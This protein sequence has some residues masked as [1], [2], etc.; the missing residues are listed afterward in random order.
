M[1][2]ASVE[3]SAARCASFAI[4]LFCAALILVPPTAAQND[5]PYPAGP[6]GGNKLAAAL[7]SMRPEENSRWQGQLKI[8]R[9][10]QTLV[11]PAGSEVLV[12]G[13]NWKVIY[14]AQATDKTAAEKLIVVH[15]TNGPNQYFYARASSPS[16]VPGEPKSLGAAEIDFP[17]ASSDFW[18][19]DL[20]FEFYHWPDQRCLKGEMRRGR[21]CYVLESRNPNPAP[22]GYSRVVSWI[23]RESAAK[24]GGGIILAEAYGP[25]NRKLKEFSLGPFTKVNGH[26]ELKWMEIVNVRANSR[27]RLEFDLD[28][29]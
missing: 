15:S 23:D 9:N 20:G 6:E 18:L 5:D 3:R 11:V 25:D 10:R 12:D 1:I 14:T 4:L 27:T 17:F 21:P 2:S 24:D 22:Q 7:R 29:K 8:T 26:W 13:A 16:A 28:S 19:S